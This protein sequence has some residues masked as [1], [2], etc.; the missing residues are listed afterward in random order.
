MD[1]AREQDVIKARDSGANE[2]LLRP[3]NAEDFCE[4]L[5]ALIDKPRAF[6]TAPN[7]KGPCRRLQG[8]TPPPGFKERRIHEVKL[9][10]SITR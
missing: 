6:I 2:V 5:I 10:K 3:I 8:K 4:K 7:Y 1:T 9:I